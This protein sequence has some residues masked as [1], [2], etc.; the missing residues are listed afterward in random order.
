M[1]L[2][3]LTLLQNCFSRIIIAVTSTQQNLISVT[4]EQFDIITRLVQKPC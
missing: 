1:K 3:T 2:K 4:K